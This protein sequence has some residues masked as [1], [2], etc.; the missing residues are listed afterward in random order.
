MSG[1]DEIQS[2]IQN[3]QTRVTSPPAM[4]QFNA[5]FAAQMAA[6]SAGTASQATDSVAAPAEGF[7]VEPLATHATSNPAQGSEPVTL[8]VMLGLTPRPMT[9]TP[10]GTVA[11]S[12]ELAHYLEIHVI[13][14]RNGRLDSSELTAVSGS[15]NGNGYLLPPAA[16]AWEEMRAAASGDGI[17]LQAIDLYRGWE[18]QNRAYQAHLSGEKT[19]NVVPPGTSQHG[20]GLAV[21]I[22][23]G[24]IINVGDPEHAWLRDNA[25]RFG[26]YPIS[27]ESWHW[28]FRGV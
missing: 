11:T 9:V 3:I 7:S 14:E 27:N 24:H 19:A 6:A 1:I 12:A 17:D 23:N 15:W 21:D 5:I 22:T 18:S 20:A 2:R 8:G 4:G 26:W 28:E 10:S 25:V 13:E 16:S